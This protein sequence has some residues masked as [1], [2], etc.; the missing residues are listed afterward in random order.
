MG[1][2]CSF[3][4]PS[5]DFL[6]GDSWKCVK[7]GIPDDSR[8]K[9]TSCDEMPNNLFR[10]VGSLA[11]GKWLKKQDLFVKN[12]GLFIKTLL[13]HDIVPMIQGYLS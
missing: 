5:H 3:V 11:Y 4:N 1:S 2:Y 6:D 12:V 13:P 10:D 8:L 9:S 7:C